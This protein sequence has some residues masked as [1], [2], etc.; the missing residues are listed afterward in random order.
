[1][2]DVAR[3]L[4]L[5]LLPVAVDE[6]GMLPG[7]LDGAL[8]AGARAVVITPRGHNPAGAA[9][10][11]A[12]ADELH[13][14][15]PPE[16]LVLEDD[17]LG[18]VAGSPWYSVGPGRSGVPHPGPIG[19]GRGAW[20]VVRSASKWLGPD[21]RVAV[22]AGD[23]LTLSRVEGR[24]SLGPGWVSGISQ[25]LAARLWNDPATVSLTGRAVE[26][27]ASRR[28]ALSAA[29]AAHGIEARARSGINL[30]IEV[31]DEDAAVRGLLVDGWAVA[32]GSP[33]RLEAGPAVRITTAAL[34]EADAERVAAAL[35][36]AVRPQ[37]RTRAA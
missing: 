1:V 6:R 19:T 4:G 18:P 25:A 3:A 9:L 23:E 33:F 27:Y 8:R 11:A 29:L 14:L 32:A 2:F 7:A 31:P 20:A 34:D 10:D 28:E 35:A 5:R 13:A 12:R 22:V 17:H 24:Q 15:L 36:R 26:T 30:W 16:V 37:L 21:L